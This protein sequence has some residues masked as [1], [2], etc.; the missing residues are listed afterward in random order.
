MGAVCS[1]KRPKTSDIE[2]TDP[3]P[4]N[5]N[6][7]VSKPVDIQA[8]KIDDA[9]SDFVQVEDKTS[10]DVRPIA[11][12]RTNKLPDKY[13]EEKAKPKEKIRITEVKKQIP[14]AKE[15][16]VQKEKDLKKRKPKPVPAPI[17][18]AVEADP[19]HIQIEDTIVLKRTPV[20]SSPKKFAEDLKADLE[21]S[22]KKR[23]P[24]SRER[25]PDIEPIPSKNLEVS[26]PETISKPHSTRSD[27]SDVSS[28][29][30]MFAADL[31]KE[32]IDVIEEVTNV[33]EAEEVG[34]PNVQKLADLFADLGDD[35][36]D[37][38]FSEE[39]ETKEEKVEVV[40]E[41]EEVEGKEEVKIDA[42]EVQ[43]ADA[44]DVKEADPVTVEE[45]DAVEVKEDSVEVMEEFVQ[46]QE[47][48]EVEADVVE[49]KEVNVEVPE[50]AEETD[51]VVE[52]TKEK[53]EAE[54]VKV[55]EKIDAPE[56]NVEPLNELEPVFIATTSIISE[57]DDVMEF[58]E[59]ES[60]E[61]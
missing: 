61:V 15:I 3:P 5:N 29:G 53:E 2:D 42:V 41:E 35:N 24:E 55:E 30:E 51:E 33:K 20:S 40:Q 21:E 18:T 52:V 36:T 37:I 8:I 34:T 28:I 38:L 47:I 14:P 25:P 27:L 48:A 7:R 54:D 1:G 50:K 49:V 60:T 31:K 43:E 4:L 12:E 16:P 39:T 46:V 59:P 22:T 56:P 11:G 45:T 58:E 26:E 44:L 10:T 19:A 17:T 23:L 9:R 57:D 13:P 32:E 6:S